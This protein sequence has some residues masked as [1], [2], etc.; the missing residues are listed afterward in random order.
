MITRPMN[1]TA[2]ICAQW[3]CVMAA[4]FFVSDLAAQAPKP[5]TTNQSSVASL[6]D[7]SAQMVR[8]ETLYRANCFVCHQLNGQGIPGIYPPLARSDFL[9]ADRERAIRTCCEGLSG[10]IVVNGKKFHGSMPAVILNDQDVADVLTYVLSSWGNEGSALTADEV[11]TVRAKTQFPTF[12]ALQ[13]ASTFPPLPPPPEGFT[14][15][16]VVR[17]PANG[18]RLASDGT[19][20]V[21]YVLC[22]NGDVYRAIPASGEIRQ[23]LWGAK[24]LERRPDDIGGPVFVLAM[25][26]DKDNR[27]YIASNQLNG[28]R[29]PV[30]NIVTIYRSTTTVDGDPAELKPWF[31]TSYPGS[32]AYMHAVEHIAFGPDGFLYVGNGARTDGGQ[33][34]GDTNYFQGGETENTACIWRLDPRTEK[35]EIEIYAR[36]LRN[37]YG[38]CWNDRGE[39]F[40]TENGPDA[41]APEELNLIERGKH[42]GFPYTFANW[43]RR[44]AYSFTPDAPA[45][46][47]FT[48]PIANLGPDGGFYG[49][50]VYT[51]DPHS[52][53]GGIVWLGNDF[54][55]G[56]R[57]T[58]LLSRFGNFIKTPK[59]NVGFDVLQ[60][61][62]KRNAKGTYEAHIRTVL[63][64]LGR[65]MDIHQSGK[66]KLFIVEYS[67]GTNSATSFS[68]AGRITELSLK[69]EK[70]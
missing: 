47:E 62:L 21:L 65:P 64:P 8:G 26:M 15:R 43:G 53:P 32:P 45:G 49:E 68:M 41:D 35:P 57:G 51:F 19:G 36:G 11:K 30:Q 39:M 55:E 22:A 18:V 29:K 58:L 61:R 14:F 69:P 27:L 1:R 17:L 4:L 23:L 24:Y 6:T 28:E 3:F 10:E 34:T 54:P 48:Q 7:K 5:E 25:T 2:F 67:R 46:M 59:D 70:P 20:R 60:A 52:G 44:K 40:A 42:Y 33:A 66:G 31:Q 63:A 13:Q 56:W 9:M 12:E 16:E 38:F 50:P 37:A